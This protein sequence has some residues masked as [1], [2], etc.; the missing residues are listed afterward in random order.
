MPVQTSHI[1]GHARPD[2]EKTYLHVPFEMPAH[3]TRVEINYRYDAQI[4]SSP[5]VT[6][7]N[8]VDLGLFDERGIDFLT[9]GFRGW[10]GSERAT[11]WIEEN[12]AAPGY[13]AGKLNPGVWHVLLGL[14]KLAPQGCNYHITVTITTQPGSERSAAD[15]AR[16]KSKSL[17][18]SLPE[19]VRGPWLRGELHCHT[20]HSDGRFSPG[21]LIER[22]KSRK[23]D[24]L[25]VSD[26]NTIAS[27]QE[28]EQMSDPGLI[29]IRGVEATTFKGHFN[30]W[31]IPN[32][33]DFRVQC[34]ED[35]RTALQQAN[36]LGAVTSCGHPKPFGPDWDY[37]EVQDFQCVEVWNGPWTGF[38]ELSL[39]YWTSLL[40]AGRRIPAVGGSDFHRAGDR[41]GGRER[42]LGTPTNWIFVPGEAS[43]ETI[44]AA[45]Q[46]G[47]TSLSDEP[48]G[49]FLELRSG[50]DEMAMMGDR[51][52]PLPDGTLPVRVHCLRASGRRLLLLDQRGKL[53][54]AEIHAGDEA[55][56]VTLPVTGSLYVRAELRDEEDHMYAL[57]NPVYI[58]CDGGI[59]SQLT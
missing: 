31:G 33:I 11:I 52:V 34:P 4:S 47:H 32:W 57:T 39:E 6:G 37:R 51:V 42:D 54:E 49:P 25:A 56:E 24:F 43:A 29:L 2:Q 9:A 10:S 8:T 30:A 5:T 1:E 44:L 26:H 35:M 55:V 58:L 18:G 7:G 50:K 22:A 59:E 20:W 14:Y 21:G 53:F 45:V 46:A 19:G 48:N 17:P 38:N 23:L 36:R 41:A 28:L 15:P 13:L 3:A 12:A 16:L 27:Q 40:A